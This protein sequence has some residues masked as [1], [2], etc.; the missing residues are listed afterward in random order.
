MQTGIKEKTSDREG[1]ELDDYTLP[2]ICFE[3]LDKMRTL[4][5]QKGAELVLIKA[6]TNSWG[7]YWY[8][9]WDEQIAEYAQAKGVTYY[10]FI[11]LAEDMGIDWSQDTYDAGAHLNVCG[12]EK[13]TFYFG[14]LLAEQHGLEDRRADA[15]L[16][17]I[18]SEKLIFYYNERNG[19]T[20]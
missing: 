2:P 11:P 4:C 17:A 14:K 12:A 9:E 15:A 3:Y 8:D 20:K 13:L 6:P 10:N 1:F 18:W 16:S 19:E 7:Y 5:E